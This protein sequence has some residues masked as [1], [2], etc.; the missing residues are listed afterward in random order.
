LSALQTVLLKYWYS[1]SSFSSPKHC[2]I[3]EL[4]EEE[5][6]QTLFGNAE[7]APRSSSWQ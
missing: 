6:R 2:M 7:L 5:T 4:T 1:S 3:Q